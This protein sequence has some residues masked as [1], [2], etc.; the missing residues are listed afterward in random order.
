MIYASESLSLAALELLVHLEPSEVPNDLLSIEIELPDEP[1][2]GAVADPGRFED[3]DWRATPAPGWQAEL[4]EAWLEDGTFLWLAVPSAVVP[5][6]R[7]VLI[8][9]AHREFRRVRVRSEREFAFDL[10]LLK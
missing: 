1:A 5:E 6:E 2:I 10:R 4:G 8:N 3:L 9:P 7:N